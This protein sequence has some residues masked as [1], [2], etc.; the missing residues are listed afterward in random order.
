IFLTSKER[1]VDELCGLQ[2]GADDFIRKPFSQRVLIERVKVLL[3]QTTS[4]NAT[5]GQ[6]AQPKTKP[7]ECVHSTWMLSATS[8][9]GA[10]IQQER[11][12]A[13]FKAMDAMG[14]PPSSV[15]FTPKKVKE[16]MGSI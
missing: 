8:V 9:R 4:R 5:S 13:A 10:Q 14:V 3:R 6:S 15:P 1:E 12:R 7:V 11:F 16:A 2:S